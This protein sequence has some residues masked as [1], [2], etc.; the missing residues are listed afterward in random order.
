MN[1][2]EPALRS[3][4]DAARDRYAA[5][6]VDAD[7]ALK[8][9]ASLP[10]SLPCWQGDDVAGLE[11][12]PTALGGGILVTGANP[13]RARTGDE[14]RADLEL[15]LSLIP[16]RHR[17][18]LHAMYLEADGAVDRDRVE[19]KHFERWLQWAKTKNLG[20]DF[21]PTYFSHP[22]AASGLTL[23]HPDAAVREFWIAHGIACRTIAADFGQRL[24]SPSWHNTWVPDGYKDVPVDRWEARGRLADSLDKV[25]AEAADARVEVDA[26][27]SKLFG[28][29][30]ESATVGSHEFYMGWASNRRVAVCLD[31]GHFHPTED[32]GDK[33]SSLLRFFPSLLLHLSRPVRWDSDHVV[34]QDDATAR[35]A[36]ELARIGQWN[37]VALGLDYFDGTLVR[38][39]AWVVGARA[40]QR[41]LLVAL[42]QPHDKLRELERSGDATGKLVLLE[43]LKAGPWGAVWD[44]FCH[45][46]GVPSIGWYDTVQ[47]YARTV[48]SKRA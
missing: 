11:K 16:G 10:L 5:W 23:S 44:W 34:I 14:L 47:T 36:E 8:T 38:P 20:L 31:M 2:S 39:A 22:L 26:V 13:G 37:R 24:S 19:T 32:V 7:A 21:N 9:L 15:A 12:K 3:A 43:D 45:T 30:V 27:E 40:V 46:A 42:L 17:V 18:N 25:H 33:L 28:I 1:P 4:Y 29:G 35:V 48:L 41:S 6:G